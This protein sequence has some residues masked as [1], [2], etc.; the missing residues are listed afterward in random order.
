MR[1]ATAVSMRAQATYLLGLQSATHT[2]SGNCAMPSAETVLV[3]MEFTTVSRSH[4]CDVNKSHHL[5]TGMASLTIRD[6]DGQ[7]HLC[8][9]CAKALLVQGV[10]HLELLLEG[11]T[12]LADI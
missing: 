1:Y 4:E 7:R 9:E 6:D 12:R 3:S 2:I 8:L 11:A 5:E 10:A